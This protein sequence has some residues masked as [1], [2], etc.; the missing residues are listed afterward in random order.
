MEGENAFRESLRGFS[1]NQ[2]GASI[3]T[4]FA[5]IGDFFRGAG[6]TTQESLTGLLSGAQTSIQSATG[7]GTRREDNDAGG[8]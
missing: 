1:T 3:G 2:A 4:G 5:K 6:E 7:L 8:S